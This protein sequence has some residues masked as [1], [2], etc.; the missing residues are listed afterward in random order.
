[1]SITIN[2]GDV[3]RHG[4]HIRLGQGRT[5]VERMDGGLPALE[6]RERGTVIKWY[7]GSSLDFRGPLEPEDREY[8]AHL[9]SD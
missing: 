8:L 6:I 7:R 4:T 9:G 1:M 5:A 2:K 3:R